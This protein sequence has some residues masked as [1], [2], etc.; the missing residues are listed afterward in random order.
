[1][2]SSSNQRSS[3]L[4]LL[5]VEGCGPGHLYILLYLCSDISRPKKSATENPDR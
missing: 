1:V 5:Q 3:E 4:K 2:R